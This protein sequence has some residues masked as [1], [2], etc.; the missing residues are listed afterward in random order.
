[1]FVTCEG[2]SVAMTTVLHLRNAQWATRSMPEG[3][4][5][6]HP[7]PRGRD[8]DAGGGTVHRG[9]IPV[10]GLTGGGGATSGVLL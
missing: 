10:S 8:S 9:S 3:G 6:G 2:E 1:M 4:T 5:A 7:L